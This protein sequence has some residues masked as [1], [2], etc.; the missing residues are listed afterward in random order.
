MLAGN[1]IKTT[2]HWHFFYFLLHTHIEIEQFPERRAHVSCSISV[3][4]WSCV[5]LYLIQCVR[6]RFS[7]PKRK[8]GRPTR[9]VSLSGKL[10]KRIQPNPQQ[11]FSESTCEVVH[12]IMFKE[13]RIVYPDNEGHFEAFSNRAE[14]ETGKIWE[15]KTDIMRNFWWTKWKT[16]E[17][18]ELFLKKR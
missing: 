3:T 14:S 2:S 10:F 4:V 15:D 16:E 7:L 11:I 17:S 12:E 9:Y 1:N 5:F 13:G 8:R 6:W 18:R